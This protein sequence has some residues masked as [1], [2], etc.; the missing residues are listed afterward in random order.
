[1]AEEQEVKTEEGGGLI[2]RLSNAYRELVARDERKAVNPLQLYSPG[3]KASLVQTYSPATWPGL[4][5]YGR[6][7]YANS[8]INYETA[9][10]DPSKSSLVMSAVR[11]L[12][13]TLPEAP[14]QVKRPGQADGEAEA[15]ENHPLV[16]LLRKPNDYYAGDNL[17]TAFAFSWILDGNCY[18]IKVRNRLG[19]VIELWYEP[20]WSIRP[21]W[22]DDR[23][24][25]F[26]QKEGDD[27]AAFITY[28]EVD[29][30]SRKYRV[31][32]SDIVH[33]RDG[34]DPHNPR[35]GWSY[36]GSILREIYGDNEV[37]NYSARLLGGSAVPPF[38]VTIDT[39]IQNFSQEDA[40][41]LAAHL[42]RR[43]TGD[44]KGKPLVV[45]GGKPEKL[46]F[47]PEELDLKMLH[48]F[49]EERFCAVTGIP[50]VVLGLGAGLDHSIYNN[51][52]QA[53]ERAYE[54]YLI[55]LYRRIAAQLNVQLM[56]DFDAKGL[57]A[58]HDL[59][60]VRALQE[61][62]DAKVKRVVSLFQSGVIT[63]NEA[64]SKTGFDLEDGG[65]VVMVKTGVQLVKK[66]EIGAE[67]EPEPEPDEFPDVIDAKSVKKSPPADE[68]EKMVEWFEEIAPEDAKGALNAKIS[69]NGSKR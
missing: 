12:G 34:N 31:E 28:Y 42:E 48:R 17:W 23:K 20:H 32:A 50:A 58:T 36:V 65:D 3:V 61:D 35:K 38:M 62:E 43:T 59:S 6:G 69:K 4:T 33:F 8:D 64:R 40:D 24:G 21:R 27:P 47:S 63:W 29:R 66:E 39:Q 41:G 45:Y 60:G 19:Q 26:Q 11:W 14:V 18:F 13:N 9:V 44:Q 53:D 56:P 68:V 49:S 54:A 55:P 25:N 37:S 1:M 46:A 15:V 16:E 2:S 7:S 52:K 30:E 5:Y 22:K 10:G 57:Y 67:P 51:V